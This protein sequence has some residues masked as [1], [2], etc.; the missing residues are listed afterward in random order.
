M[1]SIDAAALREMLATQED[2]LL[3]DVREPW[4]HE[5][6]NIGGVLY[7]LH[8]IARHVQD[9]PKDKK[10]VI[11]CRKG[12]RSVIAIQKLQQKDHFDNLYNLS[13]GIEAWQ[14]T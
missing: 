10:V 1:N 9:I 11:Y 7:P 13:G 8:D 14:E 2:I 5:A 12:I 4:E 6:Y 3:V